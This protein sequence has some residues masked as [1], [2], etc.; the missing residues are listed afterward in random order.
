MEQTAVLRV[1]YRVYVLTIVN[2][3]AFS[4]AGANGHISG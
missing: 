3:P 1:S 4:K 2:L